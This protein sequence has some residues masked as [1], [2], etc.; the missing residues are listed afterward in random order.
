MFSAGARADPGTQERADEMDDKEEF[1]RGLR[2]QAQQGEATHGKCF[3][4]GIKGRSSLCSHVA[5]SAYSKLRLIFVYFCLNQEKK[6]VHLKKKKKIEMSGFSL[7]NNRNLWECP[8]KAVFLWKWCLGKM[9]QQCWDRWMAG[10]Q[11]RGGG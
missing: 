7:I 8:W 10:G 3:G 4:V 1:C 11:R 5:F 2:G 9:R 6:D